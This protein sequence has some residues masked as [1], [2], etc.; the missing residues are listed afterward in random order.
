MKLKTAFRFDLKQHL[1]LIQEI[2]FKRDINQGR[3]CNGLI[4]QTYLTYSIQSF[5]QISYHGS[6]EG[7]ESDDSE[8]ENQELAQID[9]GT[10]PL[11]NKLILL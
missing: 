4:Y 5:F 8:G 3:K 11:P 9:R 7:V 1:I 2:F 6:G 10:C